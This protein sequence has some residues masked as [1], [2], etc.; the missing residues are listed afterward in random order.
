MSDFASAQFPLRTL[1]QQLVGVNST[2][3]GC[4]LLTD[5][6]QQST[7][8]DRV[9]VYMFHPDSHGE[10]VAET[11]KPGCEAGGRKGL[12]FPEHD[13]QRQERA[14]YIRNLFSHSPQLRHEEV[15]LVPTE[16]P[17][18]QDRPDMTL[19]SLRAQ[20]PSFTQ[21]NLNMGVLGTL[22]Y[23]ILVNGRL[24]GLVACHNC[25]P[26]PKFISFD[27]RVA[28]VMTVE[29]FSLFVGASEAQ[30][31]KEAS[32][33]S[34]PARQRILKVL[35]EGRGLRAALTSP[36][37]NIIDVLDCRGAAVVFGG[38]VHRFGTAPTAKQIQSLV[39]YVGAECK[40]WLCTA[41]L[42][43]VWE[44][45]LGFAQPRIGCLA[46]C[47]TVISVADQVCML[48]F[49]MP[50]DVDMELG[51]DPAST[52]TGNTQ[53]SRVYCSSSS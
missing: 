18:Y 49:R 38:K 42:S 30:K 41:D 16:C 21:Y 46:H 17:I 8:Y 27:L 6:V 10:V 36:Q 11:I 47:N 4:Q 40:G 22:N 12:H 39:E 44:E 19:V 7:G 35:E 5:A 52:H 2:A 34:E 14:C 48:W 50:T 43:Q 37:S 31:V 26:C 29:S 20:S 25:T 28:V 1:G 24:W 3:E 32:I 13:I 45:A 15:P 23:S 9:M 53:R 51:E 33:T